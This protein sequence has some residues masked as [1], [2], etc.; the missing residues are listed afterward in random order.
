MLSSYVHIYGLTLD[1]FTFGSMVTQM[2]QKSL[3][4]LIKPFDLSTWILLF[5][6]IPIF[7]IYTKFICADTQLVFLILD[8]G[9]QNTLKKR[10]YW[11]SMSWF[12]LSIVLANSY[13][14]KVF[15]MISSPTYPF[16]PK[17]VD[18]IPDSGFPIISTHIFMGESAVGMHIENLMNDSRDG[19]LNVSSLENYVWIKRNLIWSKYIPERIF[20]NV[21]KKGSIRNNNNVTVNTDSQFLIIDL[22]KFVQIVDKLVHLVTKDEKIFKMGDRLRLFRTRKFWSTCSHGFYDELF[23]KLMLPTLQ[24]FVESG[25]ESRWI[26]YSSVTETFQRLISI[27]KIW[28]MSDVGN[29]ETPVIKANRGQILAHL[30]CRESFKPNAILKR[31]DLDLFVTLV[32]PMVYCILFSVLLFVAEV[33]CSVCFKWFQRRYYP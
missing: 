32:T 31:V 13:K 8:Q 3:Q 23:K 16:A 24:G 25:L 28:A 27:F 21:I 26:F 30:L 5:I 33:F 20:E 29:G 4:G 12:L 17:T 15:E 1:E 7:I 2:S 18:E 9:H 10:I 22:D 14:G 6:Y 11:L 19:I